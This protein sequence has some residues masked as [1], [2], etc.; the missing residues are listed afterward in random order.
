MAGIALDSGA[1]RRVAGTGSLLLFGGTMTL[2]GV[3]IYVAYNIEK[4]LLGRFWGAEALGV[5]GRAYQLINFPTTIINASVG[6]VAFAALSR[7]QDD[8]VTY[9][10]YF[11]KGYTLVN[12]VTMPT[13][14]LCAVFAEEVSRSC[15]GRNGRLPCRSSSCWPRPCSYSG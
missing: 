6:S 15:S 10:R 8:P 13:T 12:S 2:N 14:L 3:V 4:V 1:P 7:L 11:L 5:Y 9:K